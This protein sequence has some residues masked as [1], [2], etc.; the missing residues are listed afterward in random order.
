[1]REDAA[2]DK[3]EDEIAGKVCRLR[4]F[5]TLFSSLTI[6]RHNSI[7]WRISQHDLLNMTKDLAD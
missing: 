5:T 3:A 4:L 7:I 1:M 6:T 2:T